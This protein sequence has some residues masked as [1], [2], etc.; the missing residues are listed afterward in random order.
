VLG[1]GHATSLPDGTTLLVDGTSGTITVI[2]Q[3]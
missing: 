3:S 1:V 2:D